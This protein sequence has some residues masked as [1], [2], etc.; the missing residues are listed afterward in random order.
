MCISI[1]MPE[2]HIKI[3]NPINKFW[4]T[5][6]INGETPQQMLDRKKIS[7]LIIKRHLI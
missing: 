5:F 3:N 4:Y 2:K 6:S 7:P 1:A